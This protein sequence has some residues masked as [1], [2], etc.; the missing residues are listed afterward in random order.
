MQISTTFD[1]FSNLATRSTSGSP[2]KATS[3]LKEVDKTMK[4]QSRLLAIVAFSTVVSFFLCALG[5]ELAGN[6]RRYRRQK[7]ERAYTMLY[8]GEDFFDECYID[9]TE[10]DEIGTAKAERPKKP[11][12]DPYIDDCK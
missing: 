5:V 4:E 12:S 1:C 11:I 9:D 2:A 8:D 7:K 6:A 10:D 3:Y